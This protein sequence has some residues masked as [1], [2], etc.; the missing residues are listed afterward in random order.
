MTVRELIKELEKLE[1]QDWE[2]GYFEQ[3]QG[4]DLA[5]ETAKNYKETY[6]YNDL[7]LKGED[8]TEVEVE[9]KS[10]NFWAYRI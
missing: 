5:P 1:H 8:P 2:I 9:S 7:Y 3:E 6:F 4:L 10:G